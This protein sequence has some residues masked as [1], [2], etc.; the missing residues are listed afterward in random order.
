MKTYLVEIGFGGYID[1]SETYAVE[2]DSEEEA[3]ELALQ[4]AIAD[5]SVLHVEVEGM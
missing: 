1:V 3:R 4:E 2:A 5:I